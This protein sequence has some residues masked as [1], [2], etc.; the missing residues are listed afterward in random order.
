MRLFPVLVWFC[1]FRVG[2]AKVPD[3]G[4]GL[5]SDN[6]FGFDWELPDD[7]PENSSLIGTMNPSGISGKYDLFKQFP[8]GCWSVS[9]TQAADPELI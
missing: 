1:F 7:A 6:C 8:C 2:E 9:K 5:G 4:R 3:Q